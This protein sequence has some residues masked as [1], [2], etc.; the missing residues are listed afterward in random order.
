MISPDRQSVLAHLI[1][2]GLYNDDVVDFTDDDQALKLA[3]NG[4]ASFVTA[5]QEMDRRARAKVTSL[6]RG[7]VEGSPEFDI[8][9]KKYLEEELNKSGKV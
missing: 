7:V 8:L 2:D 5:F 1:T 3:K 4:I 9:Y 6:K